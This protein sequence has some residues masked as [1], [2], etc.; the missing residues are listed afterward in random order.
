[1]SKKFQKFENK[2]SLKKNDRYQI[3]FHG[4]V[5]YPSV[6]NFIIEDE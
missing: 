4:K 3:N 2:K 1:M 6:R 5:T